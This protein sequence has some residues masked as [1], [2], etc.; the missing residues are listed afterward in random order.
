MSTKQI[1]ALWKPTK[2]SRALLT[3]SIDLLGEPINIGIF[4]NEKKEKENHP[5]YHIVRLLN[6]KPAPIDE[7]NQVPPQDDLPF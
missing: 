2:K 5:D 6:D 3:G 1:G 7:F 4:K